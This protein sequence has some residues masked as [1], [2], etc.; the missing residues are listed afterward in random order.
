MLVTL[1]N[2]LAASENELR[3]IAEQN[4][5]VKNNLVG[6]GIVM[7]STIAPSLLVK[8][9]KL[10]IEEWPGRRSYKVAQMLNK[11]F[12]PKDMISKATH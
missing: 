7:C 9:E 12:W 1:K 5:V 10:M 3:Q 4:K 8:I 6:E 2:I 11:N